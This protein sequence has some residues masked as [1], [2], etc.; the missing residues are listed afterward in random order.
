MAKKFSLTGIGSKKDKPKFFINPVT[1]HKQPGIAILNRV[2]YFLLLV[3]VVFIV[4]FHLYDSVSLSWFFIAEAVAFGLIPALAKQGYRRTAKMLLIIYINIGIVILSSVFGNDAMI[5]AFFIPTMGLSILIFEAKN[6]VLRN[7]AIFLSIL[8]YFILDYVIFDQV[9]FSESRFSI[10]RWSV[11]TAAF[12]TTWLIFN[13]FSDFRESAESRTNE[14]LE[15]EM[16][17]NRELNQNQRK[18]ESNIEE[19]E[20]ARA[21]LEQTTKAKSEFL[22]TMSHEIRTPMNAIMGMTHL[23]QKENPR[24]DQLEPLN[25]LDFSGKTLLSLIDDVLDFSKIEAGRLEF[26]HIEFQLD[27]L[28]TTII[29]SFRVMANNK[30]VTLKNRVENAIPNI[31]VGDPARLTQILNNLLS[32]AMKFTEEGEVTLSVKILDDYSET[33][34]LEF[35]VSDTGIGIAPDRVNNIFESFTQASGSTKRLYGGTGLG[36][37]ISKQLTELQGGSLWVDSE[38]DKG[39]TFYVELKFM[40]GSEDEMLDTGEVVNTDVESEVLKGARLLIAEDNLV[41]QRVMQRFL[42]RW[43]VDMLIVNNGKEAVEAV[44]REKFDAVLM[45]LQMP[46]MDGYQATTTIRR[47]DDPVK[48]KIPIVALTAAA[49]KEVREKVYACG[50]NDFLTK[51]FNPTELQQKLG[52]LIKKTTV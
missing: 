48:R 47:L 45:D 27:K 49:L 21:D 20:R 16:K 46:V 6:V 3:C 11:L 24:E 40:K 8:A 13:T 42:Q 52:S 22:A 23:L 37:T 10:I 43:E 1:S 31:L 35:S 33:V 51:P 30:N 28:I 34:R 25:I 17:M 5:Q 18:L 38:L 14:L 41:N 15:K 2:S 29:E 32:N 4:P 50:M 7:V 19:L 39:S 12:I 9:Y 26:E 44:K 36:L